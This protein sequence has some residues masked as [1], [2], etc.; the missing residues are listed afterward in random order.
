MGRP[1][2]HMALQSYVRA[3]RRHARDYVAMSKATI[4]PR[5]AKHYL[6]EHKRLVKCA[7]QARCMER[8]WR[9]ERWE[10][11]AYLDAAE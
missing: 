10:T 8:S 6:A 1:S 9:T 2:E 5:L 3:C 4:L 7:W 11:E